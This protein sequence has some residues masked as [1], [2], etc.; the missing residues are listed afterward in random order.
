MDLGDFLEVLVK[1]KEGEG[2]KE[3]ETGVLTDSL[4][5]ELTAG[6]KLLTADEFALIKSRL[7]GRQIRNWKDLAEFR[8]IL[9]KCFTRE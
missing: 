4:E 3:Q 5:I 2:E 9:V 6:L 1:E 7:D 8:D